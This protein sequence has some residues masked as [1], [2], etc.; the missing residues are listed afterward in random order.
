MQNSLITDE[1]GLECT[2]SPDGPGSVEGPKGPTYNP[3]NFLLL[4]LV[5]AKLSLP[6]VV[7]ATVHLPKDL[8]GCLCLRLRDQDPR[9]SRIQR[10][11][12]TLTETCCPGPSPSTGPLT[13]GFARGFPERWRSCSTSR[14]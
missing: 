3:A 1:L 9:G 6:V 13:N 8:P 11:P 4:R 5:I 7:R 2:R 14:T 10:H 12:A